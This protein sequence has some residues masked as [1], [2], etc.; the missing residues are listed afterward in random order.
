MKKQ[1]NEKNESRSFIDEKLSPPVSSRIYNQ[2]A[3]L[4]L[5][6]A[7]KKVDKE[8]YEH[9]SIKSKWKRFVERKNRLDAE[10]AQINKEQIAAIE[11]I[12]RERSLTFDP[13]KKSS[14]FDIRGIIK[15]WEYNRKADEA[16]LINMELTNGDHTQF[17]AY[18]T[19]EKFEWNNG[20]YIVDHNFKYYVHSAKLY[21]LNYHQDF[22]LP[23]AQKIPIAR[24][25]NTVAESGVTDIENACNPRILKQ[26]IESDV[27][28][29]VMKG[30]EIDAVMRTIRMLLYIIVVINIIHFLMFVIKSG[31]LQQIKLW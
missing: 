18:P 31:V 12:R 17:L 20:V 27:I 24:L 11:K 30:D 9:P 23:I 28:T 6:D 1:K 2:N 3:Y 22:N 4:L 29:K 26:W 8:W 21:A 16:V 7:L 13:K 10:H 15:E 25:R 19:N 5:E 14:V